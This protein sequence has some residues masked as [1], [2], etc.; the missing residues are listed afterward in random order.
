MLAAA[1]CAL[2]LAACGSSSHKPTVALVSVATGLKFAACM[3]SQGVTNFPDPTTGGS[4]FQFK[5]NPG[6]S[7]QAPAFQSAQQACRRFQPGA[8]VHPAPSETARLSMLAFARC[9]RSH[10]LTSIPDPTVTPPTP[11]NGIGDV[12]GRG[13]VF[14]ALP[15]GTVQSPAFQQA[16]KACGFG[17]G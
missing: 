17:P 5:L 9:L 8:L 6:M 16:S 1:A 7:P 3:R 15:T 13:G 2:A 12:I 14:L 10:G 11:G 4:G